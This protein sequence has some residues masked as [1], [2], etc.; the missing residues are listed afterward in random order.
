M[1]YFKNVKSYDDLKS[2]YK[3]LL[4]RNHPDNGGNLEIMKEINVEYDALFPICKNRKEPRLAHRFRKPQTAPVAS[5]THNSVGK[6][7]ATTGT[8][9]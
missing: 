3:A 4:K 6:K 7:A 1:K 2:Q 9:A 8:A 5:S